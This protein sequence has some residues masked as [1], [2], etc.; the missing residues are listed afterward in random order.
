MVGE[1]LSLKNRIKRDRRGYARA[2]AAGTPDRVAC[3]VTEASK[4]L[5]TPRHNSANRAPP[6]AS[7]AIIWPR[8]LLGPA[9]PS[10]T[11]HTKPR[12]GKLARLSRFSPH[13]IHLETK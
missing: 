2:W 6:G 5:L 7:K 11:D 9:R 1:D 13:L 8:Q 3:R 12:P 4:G 10:D